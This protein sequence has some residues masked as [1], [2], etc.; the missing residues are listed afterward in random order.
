MTIDQIDIA[1]VVEH[2][3]ITCQGE[4][5]R[6]HPAASEFDL[7]PED[8]L[9]SLADDIAKR[10]LRFP[11]LRNADGLI[12]DG[13]NRLHAC[14]MANVT[15][16]F[17]TYTG[18]D[19]VAEIVS[20]NLERRHLN[21]DERALMAVRMLPHYEA[22]ADVG[23]RPRNDAKPRAELPQVNTHVEQRRSRTK[24]ARDFNVSPRKVQQ[25]KRVVDNA[26]DLVP[27][28]TNG[29]MSLS[30]AES[31]VKDRQ[32]GLKDSDRDSWFT[33]RWLF[34]QL[35]LTFDVDVAAPR[36]A[37][38]RTCPALAYYTE[39]DDG[40]AQ[41]WR[42]LIWCNPPYSTPEAWSD[43]MVSHGRGLLLVHVPNNAKW[44]VRAQR[45]ADAVRLIQSMHFE[46]PNGDYKRPGYSLQLLAYGPEAVA[47]LAAV[48]GDMVGPVWVPA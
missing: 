41:H 13:R 15:P 14:R 25:M 47:A 2:E 27:E 7:L 23:G 42:G 39:D 18:T 5:Y 22:Q 45:A 40:L 36:E 32:S 38:H 4:L 12:L 20:C 17:E 34:D 9:Q 44:A 35:G 6:V 29:K 19:E 37:A 1:P 26:P 16:R 8:R 46:R 48:D 33:P 30:K 10:G 31:V 24:A 3:A 11:I 28:V 43:K 21:E